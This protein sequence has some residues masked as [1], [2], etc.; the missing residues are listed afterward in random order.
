MAAQLR[1]QSAQRTHEHFIPWGALLKVLTPS[2]A[3]VG[4]SWGENTMLKKL[5][6]YRET[7][8]SDTDP[9]QPCTIW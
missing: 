7:K 3:R 2:S 5:L 1:L 8:P 4:R 9:G 6:V